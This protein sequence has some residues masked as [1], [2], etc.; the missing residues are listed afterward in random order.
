MILC[1]GFHDF[2]GHGVYRLTHFFTLL[3]LIKFLFLYIFLSFNIKLFDNW[4]SW[5]YSIFF[6]MQSPWYHNRV[7]D[8]YILTWVGSNRVFLSSFKLYLLIL[9]FNILFT[10]DWTSLFS[11]HFC[12]CRVI[13]YSFD[14]LGISFWFFLVFFSMR[15]FQSYIHCCKVCNLTGFNWFFFFQFHHSTLSC[16]IT[17]VHSN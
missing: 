6:S 10:R 4:N 1:R 5:F 15:L 2:H 11:F 3:F 8:F 16:F 12:F 7:K 14:L 9:S 13:M 17:W